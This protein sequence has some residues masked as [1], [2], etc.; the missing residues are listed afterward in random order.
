MNKRTLVC[1]KCKSYEEI[2]NAFNLLKKLFNL[3]IEE[4]EGDYF[5]KYEVEGHYMILVAEEYNKLKDFLGFK[6][7]K[8]EKTKI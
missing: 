5:L 4:F 6:E 3:E 1:E 7:N 2:E 8:N